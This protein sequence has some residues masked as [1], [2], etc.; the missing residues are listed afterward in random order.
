M[1]H[2]RTGLQSLQPVQET[3][4]PYPTEAVVGAGACQAQ[5]AVGLAL[6]SDLRKADFN[7]PSFS[8]GN[9]FPHS[10][11]SLATA[12]GNT[13]CR[14]CQLHRACFS[15]LAFGV[16]G[17]YNDTLEGLERVPALLFPQKVSR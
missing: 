14:F 2:C 3:L 13:L 15:K 9:K 5:I 4:P 11:G 7:P 10:K 12:R 1:L 6:R 8:S 16:Y 17:P